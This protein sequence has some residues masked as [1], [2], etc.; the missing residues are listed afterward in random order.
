M[1]IIADMNIPFVEDCFKSIGDVTLVGGRDITAAMVK[2]ADILLV[3]SITKVNEALLAGSAV[4]FVGTATIGTDHIDQPYLEK[5]GITF[6]SAP[7]SN[8]NSVAEY[9]VASLLELARRYDF[10]LEGKTIGIIGVGNVGSRVEKKARALGMQV[11]LN[12]PPLFR[13]TGD[14]KYLPIE[15]LYD[16]DFITIHTPLTCQGQDKTFHLADDNFLAS[17]K[18][19][20]FIFNS[21]RGAVAGNDA[22]NKA[23]DQKLIAGAV[24]DVWEGEPNVDNALLSKVELG[25]QHIAGYSFDGKV[26]GMMMLYE[27]VC[28]RFDIDTV[29]TIDD[30]LPVAKIAQIDV[31]TQPG[32]DEE[33]IRSVVQ[34]VYS[35]TSDDSDM[36]KILTTEP[37]EQASLFD[38]LRKEYPIRR[39]FQNTTVAVAGDN[40]LLAK[41]LAGIGFKV[42]NHG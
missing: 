31:S 18:S 25:S 7:G 34:K 4:K 40:D 14:S 21:S 16:C 17:L 42:E 35:I 27:A 33:I 3:R 22:V 23:L 28:Q 12:D 37:S 36:R 19:G 39:E 1:K 32:T 8:A 38:R 26:A 15:D 6:S 30:F 2:D 9:I 24:L 13:A 20:V 11:K 41:K 29:N 10:V 5:A